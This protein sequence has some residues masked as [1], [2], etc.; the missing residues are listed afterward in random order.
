MPCYTSLPA[1]EHLALNPPA[2]KKYFELNKEDIRQ[3]NTVMSNVP[4]YT[5][6]VRT[7]ISLLI[8]RTDREDP[9]FPIRQ[10][11]DTCL[12]S[13][14]YRVMKLYKDLL[15]LYYDMNH[16]NTLY[17][18]ARYGG[19]ATAAFYYALYQSNI[20]GECIFI[21]IKRIETIY[22]DKAKLT[23]RIV[24]DTYGFVADLELKGLTCPLHLRNSMT[25]WS[26]F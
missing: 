5:H 20:Q 24:S 12:S 26:L 22:R 9:C 15:K 1:I 10:S 13:H 18:Q 7:Q 6:P 19:K 25:S 8:E 17:W 14:E 21:A 4:Y 23:K 2:H 16:R 3:I 11:A